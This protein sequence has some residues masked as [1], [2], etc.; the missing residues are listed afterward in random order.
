MTS[1]MLETVEGSTIFS[2]KKVF[3]LEYVPD[4]IVHRESCI[5]RIQ[6]K[7]SD[8]GRGIT[9]GPIL[10]VG[11]FRTGKTVVVRY[12]L[13]NLPLGIV[14]VYVNWSGSNT[15][16][17]VYRSVL[18]SLGEKVNTGYRGDHYFKLFKK[19]VSSV[20]GLVLVLR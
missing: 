6:S 1:D 16:N 14:G 13:R 15:Q 2:D 9:P 3:Q 8:F 5:S 20:R 7:L 10:C 18:E 4:H 19:S 11:A 12:V 17:R